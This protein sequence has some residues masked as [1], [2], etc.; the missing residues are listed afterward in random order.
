MDDDYYYYYPL[1]TE[2][3]DK[4]KDKDGDK[5]QQSKRRDFIHDFYL[6]VASALVFL[7]A[8]TVY[9][10]A[11]VIFQAIFGPGIENSVT[12]QIFFVILV[13]VVVF[14]ILISRGLFF[15]LF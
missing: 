14:T 5:D 9:N 2:S 15:N 6:I 7:L 10:A 4:D 1:S 3:K 13:A 11:L 8:Q 12:F